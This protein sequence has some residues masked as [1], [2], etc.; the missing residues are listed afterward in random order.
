[1]Q[2]K[3]N[4]KS[5]GEMVK[6][7]SRAGVRI[8]SQAI[9]SILSRLEATEPLWVGLATA[10]V[11]LFILLDKGAPWLWISFSLVLLPFVLRL[12]K[13]R[14]LTVSTPFDLP[15]L[16]FLAGCAV[17][18]W[19]SGNRYLSVRAL[20]SAVTLSSMYYTVVNYR[21]HRCLL[22]WGFGI[23]LFA[24]VI[25]AVLTFSQG[26]CGSPL[27][28]T[29]SWA[30]DLAKALPGL[31]QPAN[32]SHPWKLNVHG[33]SLSF[34]IVAALSLGV[35]FFGRGYLLRTSALL[36][37]ALFSWAMFMNASQ[38]LSRLL[39]GESLRGRIPLWSQ[40]L[41][42]MDGLQYLAGLGLG[43]WLQAFQEKMGSWAPHPHNAY[44]QLYADTG[45]LGLLALAMSLVI[46]SRIV[47][48][49][50]KVGRGHPY[51]GLV[52]GVMLATVI[53]L[54]V[55]I[56]ETPPVGIVAV[57]KEAYYYVISPLAFLL[58]ALTVML[59]GIILSD[60]GD[61]TG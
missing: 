59:R 25:T 38:A 35:A 8:P 47:W 24:V 44:V 50:L 2:V 7:N 10:L 12:I 43:Y 28:W 33:T 30:F 4:K 56:V 9:E 23:G 60:T 40:T 36:G 41:A 15:I 18:V 27:N 19:S 26:P 5:A 11:Y 14:R 34:T 46:G 53:S 37:S 16:L 31:P 20:L 54:V 6:R 42:M 58:G 1:M 55:G 32:Y 39:T 17:G 45:V 57:G 22:K 13:Y 21:D 52:V 61:G 49:L 51:Y 48:Q 29:N 3:A